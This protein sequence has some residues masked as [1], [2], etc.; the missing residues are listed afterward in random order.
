MN[1]IVIVLCVFCGITVIILSERQ[2]KRLVRLSSCID[3]AL[4]IAEPIISIVGNMILLFYGNSTTDFGQ[5][6]IDRIE[7]MFTAIVTTNAIAIP[8][9]TWFF[10]STAPLKGIHRVATGIDRATLK[11]PRSRGLVLGAVRKLGKMTS[12]PIKV[13]KTEVKVEVP[14]VALSGSYSQAGA[15]QDIS[16]VSNSCA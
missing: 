13:Q 3:S 14:G 12:G 11:V 7:R 6:G 16:V 5:D 2:D 9:L 8:I 4:S 1:T 15:S 10:Y